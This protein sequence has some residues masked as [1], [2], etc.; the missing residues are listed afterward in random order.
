[1]LYLGT[2]A[3]VGS[4]GLRAA[5]AQRVTFCSRCTGKSFL[6]LEQCKECWY[7]SGSFLFNISVGNILNWHHNSFSITFLS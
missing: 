3:E 7:R 6:D 2:T 1:M 5:Q 4:G